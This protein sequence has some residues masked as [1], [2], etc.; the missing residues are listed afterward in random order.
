MSLYYCMR[1]RNLACNV[2][3]PPHSAYLAPSV[4]I[5][6][7]WSLRHPL[8]FNISD[9]WKPCIAC[10]TCRGSAY[11]G[12][13]VVSATAWSSATMVAIESGL[14]RMMWCKRMNNEPSW[15]GPM[16][17]LASPWLSPV[18]PSVTVATK[19]RST[20]VVCWDSTNLTTFS[21]RKM[22]VKYWYQ[23]LELEGR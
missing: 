17:E 11:V 10:A 13:W 1:A 18:G 20:F 14:G 8:F 22:F 19:G 12:R 2:G 9:I 7:H 23:V 16:A 3:N 6:Y 4:W 5:L 21:S 15:S